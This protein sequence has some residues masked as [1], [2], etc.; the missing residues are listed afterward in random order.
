M[1]SMASREGPQ[2]QSTKQSTQLVPAR[3]LSGSHL[4][5]RSPVHAL[6]QV[7]GN[8][9]VADVFEFNRYGRYLDPDVRSTMERTFGQDLGHVQVHV[10]SDGD[11]VAKA[12]NGAAVTIGDHIFFTSGNFAPN[13]DRGRYV[14][15]HELA[16]VVQQRLAGSVS[17]SQALEGEAEQAGASAVLGQ[18]A[19]VRAS[20]PVQVSRLPDEDDVWEKAL[21]TYLA[22]NQL[23][24]RL[25]SEVQAMMAHRT[26][27][28]SLPSD[29][30]PTPPG[31]RLPS[32]SQLAR[33]GPDQDRSV[34]Q[35]LVSKAQKLRER[36]PVDID[37]KAGTLI[38][39]L[40]LKFK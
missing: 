5:P 38:P 28:L 26:P 16:H 25:S 8:R 10:G 36:L 33:S 29:Y 6:N 12:V 24:L 30:D 23:Q 32:T 17:K 22:E 21:R 18:H 4:T 11:R 27:Q 7:V 40:K 35:G 39:Q 34:Y 2:F 14:L 31:A 13:T 37:F 9:V 19:Q 1:M 20:S 3:G 15:A